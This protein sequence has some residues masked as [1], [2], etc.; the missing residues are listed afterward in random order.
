MFNPLAIHAHPLRAA[1]WKKGL[2]QKTR[3]LSG[4]PL[5]YNPNRTYFLKQQRP[6]YHIPNWVVKLFFVLFS[7]LLSF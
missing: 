3:V 5:K 2:P 1:R 7:F 6:I 4:V